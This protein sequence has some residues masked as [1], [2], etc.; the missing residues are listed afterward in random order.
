MHYRFLGHVYDD[1]KG[2]LYRGQGD[3]H[4]GLVFEEK[5]V[6]PLR[7][8]QVRDI[9]RELDEA[10]IKRKRSAEMD[11]DKKRVMYE[12]IETKLKKLKD[13]REGL[14]ETAAL[15]LTDERLISLKGVLDDLISLD[16]EIS[17]LNFLLG[18]EEAKC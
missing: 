8:R 14:L 4:A 10:K 7:P 6:A 9:F 16:K 5:T 3:G 17:F 11:D 2:D 15:Y 1:G 13:D 18:T 12:K